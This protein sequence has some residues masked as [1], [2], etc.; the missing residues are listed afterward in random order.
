M[1][2]ISYFV[3]FVLS[4]T[5]SLYSQTNSI[6]VIRPNGSQFKKV[7]MGIKAE[8]GSRMAIRSIVSKNE[9]EI[10]NTINVS[11]PKIVIVMGM[12]LI[13]I[14]KKI[15]QKYQEMSQIP[16]IVL[17]NE[18]FGIYMD[19]MSNSCIVTYEPKLEHYIDRATHLAGKKPKN[20]GVVFS[21]KSRELVQSYQNESSQLN[22]NL[23]TKSVVISDPENSIRSIV[24]NFIDHYSVDFMIIL[25]DHT[26]IN[27]QNINTT[28]V[29]LLS[30]LSIQIAVPSD[31]FYEL[32][33]R[34][35]SFA[36]QPHFSEIGRIVASVI[37][38]A[39]ANNWILNQKSIYTD[40]S[41]FYFRNK[42]KSISKQNQLQNNVIAS[43]HPKTRSISHIPKPVESDDLASNNFPDDSAKIENKILPASSDL[44]VAAKEAVMEKPLASPDVKDVIMEKPLAS[45]E[46]INSKNVKNKKSSQTSAKVVNN[47]KQKKDK[48]ESQS[49]TSKVIDK[50][51][52]ATAHYIEPPVNKQSF[53]FTASNNDKYDIIITAATTNIYKDLTPD[54]PVLGIGRSGDKLKVSLEDSLWYCVDFHGTPG[55]LLKSDSRRYSQNDYFAEL[56]W[57]N[58]QLILIAIF[59]LIAVSL[60][61]FLLLKKREENNHTDRINCLLISKRKKLIKYSNI[62][63]NS[64]SI[65]R[66]LKNYGFHITVSKKLNHTSSFLL[67]NL[68]DIICVDW[69]FEI[70]IQDK[71]YEI[72]KERM[73]TAD[74]ILVFYNVE[75]TSSIKKDA[76]FDDRTFFLNED[77]TISDLNKVLSMVKAKSNTPPHQH[78][79]QSKSCL[80]GK[81]TEETLS[82]IFQ[83]M[84][85]N[86]KTGCLLVEN[87]HPV[88]MIF[89]EDGIITYAIT[90]TRIAEHA[91][92]D[93]LSMKHGRFQFLPDKKPTSR[94]MQLDIV[95]VLME[96]AKLI[97]EIQTSSPG[98]LS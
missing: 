94:Q 41:I 29:P 64:I 46:P 30:P 14:W 90:K 25:D 19:N 26:V 10:I 79:D 60:L 36:I 97:D 73:L 24:N 55:F 11:S 40:K 45:V 4:V 57:L 77:F 23:H 81:I 85:T 75:D 62:N 32:E 6:V 93:I 22:V 82:E 35:G 44:I 18:F 43:Y 50:S 9:N 98:L 21:S 61:I 65:V 95:A 83:M 54:F 20:I 8:I 80:E 16:S 38:D 52:E 12:E 47:T 5:F 70:D 37:N 87:H 76:C 86:K 49:V 56:P 17:E 92:F 68:P 58:R 31:Y 2:K 67:L 74:F 63:N 1:N 59:S 28:W 89:F 96:K 3:L 72:L 33:P 15:Q 69:Q 42:D 39:E 84:D 91:V 66:Y 88:G 51:S 27:N 34:I 7:E 48:S 71:I 13:R 78:S 53:H